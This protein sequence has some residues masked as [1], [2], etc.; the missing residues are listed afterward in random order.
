M[1]AASELEMTQ[2]KAVM[3][4]FT[5]IPFEITTCHFIVYKMWVTE[6]LQLLLK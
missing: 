3:L 4:C 2:H 5:V 1:I 6:V